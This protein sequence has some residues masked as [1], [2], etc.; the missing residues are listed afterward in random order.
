MNER[1]RKRG[2][3][4]RNTHNTST[5]TTIKTKLNA[6]GGGAVES[7]DLFLFMLSA[8]KADKAK[9]FA[10]NERNLCSSRSQSTY[11]I[12]IYSGLIFPE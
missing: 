3:L 6:L 10:G 2:R 4:R 1:E 7:S 11:S 5:K 8:F 9:N 12:F